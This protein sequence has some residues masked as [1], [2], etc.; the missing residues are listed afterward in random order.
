MRIHP[1]RE[2]ERGTPTQ[3]ALEAYVFQRVEHSHSRLAH[4]PHHTVHPQHPQ[5]LPLLEAQHR[6]SIQVLARLHLRQPHQHT[7]RGDLLIRQHREAVVSRLAGRQL[8]GFRRLHTQI[9]TRDIISGASGCRL[10]SILK[11]SAAS[12]PAAGSTRATSALN[13]CLIGSQFLKGM[14]TAESTLQGRES[15]T[16][17]STSGGRDLPDSLIRVGRDVFVCV[18]VCPS[19]PSLSFMTCIG[20]RCHR[21]WR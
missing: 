10:A 8:E 9:N 13:F 15:S 4:V 11:A 18:C 16:R 6:L 2:R 19:P 1:H 14:A 12:K 7:S 21:V 5:A 17:E 3:A 20:A